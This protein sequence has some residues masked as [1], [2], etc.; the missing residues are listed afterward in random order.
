MKTETIDEILKSNLERGARIEKDRGELRTQPPAYPLENEEARAARERQ[1]RMERIDA[2]AAAPLETRTAEN[3]S[4]DERHEM[5]L[6]INENYRRQLHR[7]DPW[8][9]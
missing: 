1:E 7:G 4:P 6:E 9:L 3:V 8:S 2:M 5:G